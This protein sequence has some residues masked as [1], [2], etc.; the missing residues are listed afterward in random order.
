MSKPHANRLPWL[1]PAV[2]PKQ[3]WQNPNDER[4]SLGGWTLKGGLDQTSLVMTR[5]ESA[6][7]G[8]NSDV[9][10]NYYRYMDTGTVELTRSAPCPFTCAWAGIR[11]CASQ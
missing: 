2:D 5:A 10:S 6:S 11:Q 8:G 9:G 4:V 7:C 3:T 1:D